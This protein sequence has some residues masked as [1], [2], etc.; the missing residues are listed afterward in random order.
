MHYK[1]LSTSD[2]NVV[3]IYDDVFS[4]IE[5]KNHMN[6][7]HRAKYTINKI[8]SSPFSHNFQFY[9]KCNLN[10]EDVE[11][12]G[13]F[14][15][16]NVQQILKQ[17]V[18]DNVEIKESWFLACTS[19]LSGHIFHVDRSWSG[20]IILSY[21]LNENWEQNW[22]GETLFANNSGECEIA[23]QYNPGRVILYN[24]DTFHASGPI[25]V[26][27]QIRYLFVCVLEAK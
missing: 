14:D 16:Q 3:H 24:A 4:S 13:V 15:N 10:Q 8:T 20:C 19:T 17:H 12:F 9:L 1:S 11:S 2:G 7:S 21:Y 5:R 27:D 6:T 22:H 26:P 18:G 25:T 23:V